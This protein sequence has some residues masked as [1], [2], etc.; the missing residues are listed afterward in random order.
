MGVLGDVGHLNSPPIS[1]AAGVKQSSRLPCRW[2]DSQGRD[3]FSLAKSQL[4][5][6]LGESP[7]CPLPA[8]PWNFALLVP[9]PGEVRYRVLQAP[10]CGRQTTDSPV[11]FQWRRAEVCPGVRGTIIGEPWPVRQRRWGRVTRCQKGRSPTGN[12]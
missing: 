7:A 8:S 1:P 11:R 9:L 10:Q 5:V 4:C 12:F 6:D 2:P 3:T